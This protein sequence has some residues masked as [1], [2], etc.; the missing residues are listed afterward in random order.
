MNP[1]ATGLGPLRPGDR[2]GLVATAGPPVGG[3]LDE[4]AGLLSS[5]GLTPVRYPSATSRH[6]WAGYLSGE[7]A[8]RSKDFEDAWCDRAIAGIFCIRG[9]YGTVRMLDALDAARMRAA[10]GKPVYGSSDVTAVLEWL[11]ERLG[12]AGWF[13]P[14]VAT[15]A[16]LEDP[17]SIEHLRS[18]VLDD[19]PVRRWSTPSAQTLVPG[20]ATGTLIGGNL[21]LLAM[22]LG[23]RGR[24]TVDNTGTIALLEDVSEDTYR[25]DG[26]L[27]SLLRAGWFDGVV[28]VALGS[29]LDCGPP[30][31]IGSLFMETL[32]P[33]GIPIAGE[34][35][36][37]HCAAAHSIPLGVQG[38]MHAHRDRPPE[39]V[40]EFCGADGD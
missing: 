15:D 29:W 16:L 20:S 14:M 4:A 21:S 31:E 35:G 12:A 5:W 32:G 39:L 25:I 2:V 40:V 17:A 33:L 19:L 24:G 6:S 8:L 1:R 30:A 23:E 22:T 28:G 18:A 13:T 11:R 10:V 37:G 36:F 7:D 34:L 9:G 38:S 3:Q 26:Y 27:R